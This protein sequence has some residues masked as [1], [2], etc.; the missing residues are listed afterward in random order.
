MI[1]ILAALT[2]TLAEAQI[3]VFAL[4][5]YTTDYVLIREDTLARA[6]EALRAAGYTVIDA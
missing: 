5:T 1:G 2:R 4:S 6:V 3:S